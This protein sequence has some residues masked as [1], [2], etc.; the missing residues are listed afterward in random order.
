MAYFNTAGSE[1]GD[2]FALRFDNWGATDGV[3][4]VGGRILDSF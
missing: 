3:A 2:W 1:G 4:I